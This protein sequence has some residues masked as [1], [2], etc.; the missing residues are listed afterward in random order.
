LR[1]LALLFSGL[2][3]LVLAGHPTDRA[4]AAEAPATGYRLLR[5]DGHPVKFGRPELG[6]GAAITYAFL[7][8]PARFPSA[9]NCQAM[10]AL[11]PILKRSGIA[12]TALRREAAAA[13]AMWEKQADISFR[14][15][16]D[17][18][19]ADVLIGVELEARGRAFTNVAYDK[20]DPSDGETEAAARLD[21]VALGRPGPAAPRRINRSL[22][23]LNADELWKIGFDGNNQI[24]DLRYTFAHEIGH[25]IG[26]DHP[27]ASHAVMNFRYGE[28]F[29]EL[30]AGDVAGAIALYGA[31]GPGGRRRA[32]IQARALPADDGPDGAAARQPTLSLGEHDAAAADR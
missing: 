16:L 24:Y 5:L 15:I 6:A 4:A 11:D 18:D 26:L 32:T 7:T 27:G 22:I 1:K 12:L 8:R 2:I 31:K 14:R 19:R 9:R 3:L 21:Y 23:C 30:Q 29:R 25:A 28:R 10:G 17:A 13:F 20:N